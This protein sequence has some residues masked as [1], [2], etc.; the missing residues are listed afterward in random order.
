V[1]P[2]MQFW[3]IL[4]AAAT[5]ASV[6]I[7]PET[8][9]SLPSA[10]A[11]EPK[12]SFIDV[13][14]AMGLKGMSAGEAAWGDLNNDGWVDLSVGGQVWRNEQGKKFVKVADLPGSAVWG[15]FDNDGY[16]DLFCYGT[17]RLYR[18]LKGEKFEEV[19]IL[20]KLPTKVC[21]G[22]TFGD[23]NNDGFLDLYVGGYEIWPD[24][25]FPDVILMSEKGEKF[26]E[27]WRQ[28][29][30]YRARGVTAADFD[31]DGHLDVFVSNYRLMQ[32]LLWKND[33]KGKFTDVSIDHGAAGNES[34]KGQGW[35]KQGWFGHTIGSCWGDL[36]NDGHLDLFVGN[37][38]HPP[39]FQD[40]SQFLRNMGP[41]GKF[42]FEDKT[43]VANLRWQESYASPTLGDYD[44]DGWLDLYF[45]TVYSGDKSVLYQ[46]LG[47]WKFQE[48]KDSAGIKPALTYQAAW[49]DFDNDGQ[50]DLVTGGRLF[51]NPGNKNHWLKVRLEGGGKV[52]RA[53]IGTQVR[54]RLGDQTLTRQVEGATGQGNQNDLTLHFGL[55]GHKEDVEMEIRWTD[56]TRQTVKTPADRTIKV[57]R[58]GP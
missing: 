46:N 42:H 3:C 57:K 10:N 2:P 21:L 8:I 11:G 24:E 53:A 52:N 13:T 25:Q 27:T 29:K 17:G 26:V 7:L 28:T 39:A 12:G 58:G 9:D 35:H 44:N 36:D 41:K 54:L 14:E 48:I 50:L 4:F 6:L 47:Q 5:A 34:L 56:G 38:S 45:T 15:D 19:K 16:L 43:K 40:R 32:N 37:F 1:K 31:E 49:A 18:N 30:I 22:A 20:P 23:F 33:G 55:G 51:R